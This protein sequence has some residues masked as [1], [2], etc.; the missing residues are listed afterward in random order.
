MFNLCY[1]VVIV[2]VAPGMNESEL[3]NSEV[4]IPLGNCRPACLVHGPFELQSAG[5]E[6]LKM[7]L[8]GTLITLLKRFEL[9]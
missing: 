2:T 5:D 4:M 1:D 6:R 9:K 3:N 8:M 7:G